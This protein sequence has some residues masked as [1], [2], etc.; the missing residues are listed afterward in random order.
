MMPDDVQRIADVA[1]VKGNMAV[2][3]LVDVHCGA[4]VDP[5]IVV[6][7]PDDV[8]ET[9]IAGM[10]WMSCSHFSASVTSARTIPQ[11]VFP[12]EGW[13]RGRIQNSW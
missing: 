5:D 4:Q 11:F 7:V 10:M 2:R 1:A 13:P 6:D 3:V 9:D 8:F 12:F